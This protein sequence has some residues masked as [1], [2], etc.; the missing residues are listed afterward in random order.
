MLNNDV[1]SQIFL[2]F[3]SFLSNFISA[4]SGGGAGLI[5]LPAL[6]FLG[7]PL[8]NGVA[9]YDSDYPGDIFHIGSTANACKDV[10][11]KLVLE[12]CDGTGACGIYETEFTCG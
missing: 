9:T 1:I 11:I 12:V 5:Q 10:T 3:I 7:L 6:L 8:D 2:G 4:L